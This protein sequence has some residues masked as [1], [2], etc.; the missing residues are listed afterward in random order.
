MEA[1]HIPYKGGGQAIG[2]VVAGHVPM[3]MIVGAGRQEPGRGRQGQGM[4]V[5]SPARSPALPNV[6]T[7]QGSRRQARRR[8]A[9]L[10]VRHLRPEGHAGRRQGQAREGGIDRHGRPARARAP[11]QARHHARLR[12]RRRRCGPSSK[13][14][15][16]TGRNS[17]TRRASSR[18]DARRCDDRSHRQ[19]PGRSRRHRWHQAAARGAARGPRRCAAAG[20]AAAPSS[21]APAWC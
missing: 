16:R 9:A 2:D 5:T 8:G 14:R 17:S 18:N 20:S 6:P 11:G 1:I 10:L 7:L 19:R 12:A 21:A 3:T 15:S 4:A 13:A